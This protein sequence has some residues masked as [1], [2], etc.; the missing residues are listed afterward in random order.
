MTKK[1]ATRHVVVDGSNIGG[2][3]SSSYTINNA[4]PADD[5][6]YDVRVTNSCGTVTSNDAVLT[7]TPASSDCLPD[8][9]GDGELTAA[10]FT[11]WINAFNNNLPEC[12]QNSNGSCDATDFTAWIAN[13]NTG[14]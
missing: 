4:T 10:D 13:Y 2:A 5:G 3:T 1:P 12:D 8:V 11:A 7:V 6:D 14:C 9:N